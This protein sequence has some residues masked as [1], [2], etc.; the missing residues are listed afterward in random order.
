MA[1]AEAILADLVAFPTVAGE[2]NGELVDYV[3]ARVPGDVALLPG[4]RADAV[5]LHAVIGPDGPG[6]LVL[7]AHSDV[8][9]VEGQ[10]WSR[11]PF[12]LHVADGRAYGRGT[13]DMK[14]FV[15]C[16]LAA[17]ADAEPSAWRRPLHLAL[18]S[19]EE[20]G[21]QGVDSLLDAL[22]P[23]KVGRVVVGEPTELRI[24]DRHKGK[25]AVRIHLTGR[26]SHS[27]APASGVNAVA[28]AGRLVVAVLAL[29]EELA[30]EARDEAFDTPH[31][32]LGIGPIGGGIALNIVPDAC[33]LDVEVRT[34]PGVEPQAVMERVRVAAAPLDAEMRAAAPEAGI[35][36]EAL[37][38]YP[39]LVGRGVALDFG[40]EAGLYQRALDVP[41]HVCG[42][43]SMAQAHAADEYIELAQLD[44]GTRFVSGLLAGLREGP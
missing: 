26:A 12:A 15:A 3:A 16:V 19:D 11:D 43:G 30:G 35:A 24:A 23:R 13:A 1:T 5:N 4:A 34:L 41:V 40:T 44:A 29:Q 14:G 22:A 42:P 33:R 38:A 8:V 27:S 21:C 18:S 32:T 20:L 25:A 7:S 10:P 2:P 36:F 37:A 31:T 9:G 6:G 17:L 39:G 28:Y